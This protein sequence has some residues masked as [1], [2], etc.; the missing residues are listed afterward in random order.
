MVGSGCQA[1]AMSSEEEGHGTSSM[2]YIDQSFSSMTV[3]R[4]SIDSSSSSMDDSVR[5]DMSRSMANVSSVEA[6]HDETQETKE[7]HAQRHFPHVGI[8]IQAMIFLS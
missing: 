1:P 3:D 7:A 2:L 6:C 8:Q 5:Y 4:M